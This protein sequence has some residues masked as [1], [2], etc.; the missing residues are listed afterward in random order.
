MMGP[1]LRVAPR[2]LEIVIVG[3]GRVVGEERRWGR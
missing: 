1:S 2:D 3:H